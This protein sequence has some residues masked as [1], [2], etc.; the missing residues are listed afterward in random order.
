MSVGPSVVFTQLAWDLRQITGALW[1]C[2]FLDWKREFELD[3]ISALTL[4]MVGEGNGNK[5]NVASPSPTS[6]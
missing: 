2:V 4:H 3:T 1:V 6:F 5:E